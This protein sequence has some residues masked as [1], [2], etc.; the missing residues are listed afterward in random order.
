MLPGHPVITL[1]VAVAAARRSKSSTN[2]AVEQLAEAGVLL[3][4]SESRR[5]R[6]WEAS[7]LLDLLA[8]LE[9]EA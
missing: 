1:P 7:G 6:A 9:A 3:P 2:V 5:N 8:D 4:V